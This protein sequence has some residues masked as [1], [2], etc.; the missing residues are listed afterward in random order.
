M[1]GGGQG[2]GRGLRD[3][4]ISGGVTQKYAVLETLERDFERL[5]LLVDVIFVGLG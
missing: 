4:I 5:E 3:A 1:P 2:R